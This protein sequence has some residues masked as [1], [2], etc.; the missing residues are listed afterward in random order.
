LPRQ[1]RRRAIPLSK[2]VFDE[3][4]KVAA[5]QALENER[6]V[7]G[8]SVYEFEEEFARFCGTKFAVST[9]SGTAALVL[10]LIAEEVQ[11][12][13]VVTTPMSFVASANSIIHAGASPI[14]AD[15][16][17]RDYTIDPERVRS[18]L[19]EKTRAIMPVH[20]FGF[21][22]EM[23]ELRKISSDRG[24]VL[25]EDASQA[26]GAL[27]NGKKVGSIGDV[28]CFSF[29]SSKNMTVGGDGG[30]VVTDNESIAEHVRSLRD[31]GRAKGSKYLH[32]RVGFTERLNTVQAA[33]GRV[34]LRRLDKWNE[35]RR[36]IAS[37]YDTLLSD[38]D[39]LITPP[40]GN[41][42]VRPVYHMY[43]VRCS[44]RDDLRAWLDRA[45]VETGIHYPDPIHLQPIYREMFGYKGGE[46]PN[47]EALCSAALSIPMHPSLSRDEVRFVSESIHE[48]YDHRS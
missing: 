26:H 19:S 1:V 41:V 42:A 21:P 48:F 10:S 39:D 6:F 15:I 16:T 14:F 35:I 46:F 17:F 25:I 20:L 2:P 31:C 9:G 8:E 13:E 3:E 7:L 24:I 47:S 43:V 27:Y 44:R 28:G 29:F 4:M 38:L 5:V 40:T 22:A 33:I 30:M 11:N 37:E 34:Q 18:S 12:T 36:E 32:T 45:G 23:G